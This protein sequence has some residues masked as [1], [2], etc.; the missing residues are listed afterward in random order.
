M[1]NTLTGCADGVERLRDYL[2]RRP[3]LAFVI[4]TGRSLVEAR[5]VHREWN[6]PDPLAWI[7]AVGSEVHWVRDGE[8]VRDPTFP[9]LGDARWN[10]EAV[11]AL[12][13]ADFALEPQPGYEQRSF[14][15][16]YFTDGH[17]DGEPLRTALAE[18]GIAANVIA[19]HG[20]FVDILPANAGKAAAMRHVAATLGVNGADVYAAGDSGNDADMLEACANAIVVSNY[21]PEIA[22]LSKRPE[23]Y[24]ARGSH[25]NG[26]VEGLV[27]LQRHRDAQATVPAQPRDTRISA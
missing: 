14:K 24:L 4:A 22:R 10:A 3:G 16:S 21:A 27:A 5:R 12:I 9:V 15:R 20:R 11:T 6:L 19:S 8:L 23:V 13:A 2:A 17:F 25:A 26:A 7:T 18:A 1:D